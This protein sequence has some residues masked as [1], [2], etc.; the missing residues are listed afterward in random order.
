MDTIWKSNFGKLFLGGCGTQVGLLA[1][2]AV[3]GGSILFCGMCALTN[4]VSIAV[5]Y[6]VANS[7]NQAVAEVAANG[8]VEAL[9]GE[10]NV[11]VAEV[12]ILRASEAEPPD[13]PQIIV[14]S[15]PS[16]D[17]FVIAHQDQAY[18]RGGP[19]EQYNGLATM[20]FGDSLEIVGRNP[21]SSWWLVSSSGGLAWVSGAEVNAYNL[22]DDI[23]VLTIP[24]LLALPGDNPP[25]GGPPPPVPIGTP[26]PAPRID[27]LPAIAGTPTATVPE[28]R[29]SVEETV[30]YKRL[31]EQL[32][33]PPL[34]AS[35]SPKGEQIAVV[36]GIK[37]Y[38]VAGDGR[39][40]QVLFEDD[41]E[42]RP[43]GDAVWS[44]DGNYIAF[45]VE[46][47]DV[48]CKSCRSVA[49]INIPESEIF[50]LETPD[51]MDSAGPRWTQ[52][53]RLLVNVFPGE[54]ADGQT[55]IYDVS[56]WGI[57]A[58]GLYVLSSSH[59]GQRYLPWHPGRVWQANVSERPDT[60]YP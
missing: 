39:Y 2:A 50:F 52:D 5:A 32:T 28:G 42:K 3:I 41:G 18:L 21:D 13:V 40:G 7:N 58:S 35:F 60:Y 37:L 10:I 43:V 26:T 22:H 27:P 14:Q 57:P 38:L 31:W 6:E 51:D 45:S 12:E 24:A 16:A 36:D 48:N 34:S 25:T 47:K 20:S 53:G 54:P 46:F 11:L 1:A 19:G 15:A 44:P 29:I 9:Q 4:V 30:G 33:F 23:P 49:L 56:G 59:E 8:E 17:P 55:Y